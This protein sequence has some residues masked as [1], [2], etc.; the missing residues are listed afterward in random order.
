[1]M[2]FVYV[3]A[4]IACTWL[5]VRAQSTAYVFQFGPTIGL[6]KWDNSFEREPLF[7]YHGALSIESVDNEEDKNSLF[8]QIGYHIKGSANRFRYYNINSGAPAGTFTEEFRF[9]NLS[10]VLGAKQKRP[11]GASGNARFYYGGG[12]RVDYTLS[13]NIDNL[14]NNNPSLV[15]FYPSVGFMNRWMAGFTVTTGIEF[16]LS[17]LIGGELKLSIQPDVTLQ[18]NQPAIGN[19]IDPFTPGNIIT[20][21]ERRIR[22]AAVELGVGL[23]LLRKVEYVDE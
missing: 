4:L 7:K 10:L 8:M 11:F 22:N 23:R 12:L 13:T 5:S 15:L 18:Y 20:I 21:S 6:Q 19:V 3:S 1:M 9:N 17:E 16:K 2:R 14:S